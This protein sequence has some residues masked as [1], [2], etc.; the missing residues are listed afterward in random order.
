MID[1]A[2][3]EVA[4][5]LLTEVTDLGIVNSEEYERVINDLHSIK[6]STEVENQSN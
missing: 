3:I 1:A 5:S 6:E 4:L 2:R